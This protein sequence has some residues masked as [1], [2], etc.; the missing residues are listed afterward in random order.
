M[1][2]KEV[3]AYLKEQRK[4]SAKWHSLK[5]VR[6]GLNMYGNTNNVKIC[7]DLYALAAANLIKMKGIGLIDHRK[8]FR[9][10]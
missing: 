2:Q 4:K 8:V 5:D 7:N 6:E 1:S 10:N 9:Y 3:L